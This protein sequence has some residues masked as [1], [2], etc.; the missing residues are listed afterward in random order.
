MPRCSFSGGG[1]VEVWFDWHVLPDDQYSRASSRSGRPRRLLTGRGQSAHAHSSPTLLGN[2]F[3]ITKNESMTF[4]RGSEPYGL[5]NARPVETWD[6]WRIRP[7]SCR[8]RRSLGDRARWRPRHVTRSSSRTTSWSCRPP[9]TSMPGWRATTPSRA[10]RS[11]AASSYFDELLYEVSAIPTPAARRRSTTAAGPAPGGPSTPSPPAAGRSWSAATCART[12]GGRAIRR[13]ARGCRG[14]SRPACPTPWR[15]QRRHPRGPTGRLAAGSHSGGRVSVSGTSVAA[16]QIVTLGRGRPGQG[17]QR[18]RACCPGPGGRRRGESAARSAAGSAAAVAFQAATGGRRLGP[19]LDH[20]LCKRS[21][22]T[23][24]EC[25][26]GP[27]G[28]RSRKSFN[29]ASPW[30]AASRPRYR[31]GPRCRRRCGACRRSAR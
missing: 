24:G 14:R 11:A 27:G 13:P 20:V 1:S 8:R 23:N 22:D 17:L 26:S 28:P 18:R 5:W 7:S 6:A 16:P 2:S 19:R 9:T 12:R 4:V 31:H 25:L 3:S 15:F 21:S 30:P 29:A 10:I